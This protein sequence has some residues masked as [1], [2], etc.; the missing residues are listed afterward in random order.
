MNEFISVNQPN[1]GMEEELYLVEA[2]RSGWI[3]SDG[4]FVAEFEK[5]FAERVNRKFGITVSNGSVALELG[6]QVLGI[7]PG[8][9]VIVPTFT[10][11]S[12]LNAIL[13][14]GATPIFIDCLED[15]WNMDVQKIEEKINSKT[16]AIMVV[17]IYGLPTEMN[18]VLEIAKK[19]ELKIIEDAA[20]A[21]GQT[22]F[23]TPCGSFG[24]LS[25]FSF[26]ANKHVTMGEG[27]IIV[28][29]NENL[30]NKCKSLRNL[31]FVPEQRFIHKEIG[32]NYRITNLQAAIGLAQ[33]NKLEKTINF[34]KNLGKIYTQSFSRIECLQIPVSEKLGYENH[35][36]V[37]GLVVNNGKTAKQNMQYLH[38]KG[39]GTRPFFWPLHKQPLLEKLKVKEINKLPVSENISKIGLYIP[40]GSGIKES[41]IERTIDAV[42]EMMEH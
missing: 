18:P 29:N 1:I 9:E 16:K 2:I 38:D 15:T 22:Y 27:G 12:C 21:H 20:E 6:L 35:Y 14:L 8:D 25:I 30:A 36:W 19:Y 17:H 34:K 41:H 23:G 10:I 28:T 40:S 11:I 13:K 31:C 42:L 26:Y 5:K 39:I 4:P 7:G 32:S 24:D 33:L 37:Y 3:S